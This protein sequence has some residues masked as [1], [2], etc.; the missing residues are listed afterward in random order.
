MSSSAI[1]DEEVEAAAKLFCKFYWLSGEDLCMGGWFTTSKGDRA[2]TCPC[3]RPRC[4]MTREAL[5]AAADAREA[6]VT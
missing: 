5:E 1:L 2:P 3:W 6:L 4:R